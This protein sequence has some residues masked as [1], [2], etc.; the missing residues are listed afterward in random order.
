MHL[1]QELRMVI[2]NCPLQIVRTQRF[3]SRGPSGTPPQVLCGKLRPSAL[4]YQL[5]GCRKTARFHFRGRT[6]FSDFF[7]VPTVY[8]GSG[9]LQVFSI[10][11]FRRI[12]KLRSINRAEGFDS[13]PARSQGCLAA[14]SAQIR[15]QFS[16]RIAPVKMIQQY[17]SARKPACLV[18]RERFASRKPLGGLKVAA[19]AIQQET[20]SNKLVTRWKEANENSPLSPRKFLR[21]NTITGPWTVCVPLLRCS[22]TWPSGIAT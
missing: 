2:M 1:P 9:F 13:V 18:P 22:G 6:H 15:P 10:L 8:L 19:K 3:F 4:L 11:S 12:S 7:R 14:Q 21:A 17:Q 20:I 5:S 16:P